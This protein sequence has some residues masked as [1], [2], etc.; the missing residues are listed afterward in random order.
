MVLKTSEVCKQTEDVQNKLG[1]SRPVLDGRSKYSLVEKKNG[2]GCSDGDLNPTKL[3]CTRIKD[4]DTL[5]RDVSTATEIRTHISDSGKA[6]DRNC[7]LNSTDNT[8]QVQHTFCADTESVHNSVFGFVPLEPLQLYTGDPVYHQTIPDI[9]STHFMIR[10]SGLPNF[11]IKC[12]VPVTS[13]LNVDRWRSHLVDYWD[14]QLPDLLEY[15]FPIDFDR[16]FP[17]MSTLVN[18]TS[19]LQ[20]SPHVSNY[21]KELQHK[22]IMGPFIEPPFPIHVSPLMTRDKHEST[23]KRT[24]MDLSCP[25]GLSINNG[26]D[27]DTYLSTSYL[28]NY[29]SIDNITASLCKLGPAA[30]LFKIDISRAFRQIKIDPGDIDLLGM[31]FQ[32]HYFLDLSVP[33]G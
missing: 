5:L 4:S 20:N 10:N 26:V 2:T 27:K 6:Y 18:H 3:A 8:D 29:L 17:L 31:K 7:V 21:L 12:R 14:Q 16:D 11:Q 19:A 32:D 9:I 13:K 24:I 23:Q 25:K 22:A 30:Q 28:L 15:G 33:F 1:V